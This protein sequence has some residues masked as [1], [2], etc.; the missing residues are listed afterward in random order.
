MRLDQLFEKAPQS[1]IFG[2]MKIARAKLD[3]RSL[4]AV[5]TWETVNWTGGALEQHIAANDEMAQDIE[6][7]FAPVRAQLPETITLYRGIILGGDYTG[8]NKGLLASWSSDVRTAELFAGLRRGKK[9]QS[10]LHQIISDEDRDR[11]VAQYNRTGYLKLRGRHYI[12]NKAAPQYFNIYDRH[13]Q[14]ITDGDDIAEEIDS[15]NQSAQESN[16][17]LQ[18]KAK[19]FK[20]EIP[21]ERVVWITNQ[22]NCKEF[23]VRR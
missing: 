3:S 18:A 11:M 6:A 5:D 2:L 20:E 19:V 14:F 22:L 12:R 13:R 9:W 1:N 4:S 16:D 10:L 8:W 7:A 15:M 23:I 17:A 21:R